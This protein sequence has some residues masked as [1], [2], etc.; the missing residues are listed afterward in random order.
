MRGQ[1]S[2]CMIGKA[3]ENLYKTAIALHKLLSDF[4]F[5]RIPTSITLSC[6]I[7]I[8]VEYSEMATCSNVAR[9]MRIILGYKTTQ[10][11]LTVADVPVVV[12]IFGVVPEKQKHQ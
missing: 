11:S 12:G 1:C 10:F 2:H 8:L 9:Q 6:S 7:R 5:R 4:I 3:A